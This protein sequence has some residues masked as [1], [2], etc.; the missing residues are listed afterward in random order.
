MHS[1]SLSSQKKGILEAEVTAKDKQ[2]AYIAKALDGGIRKP[3][4]PAT[5]KKSVV[6]PG[7]GVKLNQQGNLARGFTAKQEANTGTEG[8]PG[9]LFSGTITS[10]H[11][12]RLSG[13]FKREVVQRGTKSRRQQHRL[14]ALVLFKD[15]VTHDP[16]KD[17]WT[18]FTDALNNV[19]LNVFSD[20]RRNRINEIQTFGKVQKAAKPGK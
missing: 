16:A 20:A 14:K 2:D 4:D 9:K 17:F 12:E 5:G 6:V 13:I 1:P 19:P 8:K 10:R 7:A 15:R 3:G 11:G 18:A